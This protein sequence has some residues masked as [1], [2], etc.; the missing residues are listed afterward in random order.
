[1]KYLQ[2]GEKVRVKATGEGAQILKVISTTEAIID[3]FD[4]ELKI[5]ADEVLAFAPA[6]AA[7]E[8][9]GA[10]KFMVSEEKPNQKSKTES[11]PFNQDR[12]TKFSY[13]LDLHAKSLI[14][15][16]EEKSNEEILSIQLSRLKSY[17]KEAIELHIQRVYIIHGIGSGR[18]KSEVHSILSNYPQVISFANDYHPQ[19][20]KGSTEVRLS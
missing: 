12:R 4:G 5:H 2:K 3:T 7:I 8:E 14:G 13:S 1:M 17:L 15:D 20:G 19:Y 9:V 6:D 16:I 10:I 18:L 11:I